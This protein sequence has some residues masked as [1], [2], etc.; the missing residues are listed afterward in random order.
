MDI[1][2]PIESVPGIGPA[3]AVKLKKR[4]ILTVLDIIKCT[5]IRYI[6]FTRIS[7][8]ESLIPGQYAV[9]AGKIISAKSSRSFRKA[10]NLL[11]IDVTDNSGLICAIWFNQPFLSSVLRI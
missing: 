6:D 11:T 5:P 4:G 1:N 9:I 2:S 10:M 7:S 8:I 3:F